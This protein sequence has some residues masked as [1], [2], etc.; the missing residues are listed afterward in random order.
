MASTTTTRG[1]NYYT[2]KQVVTDLK[3]T[4]KRPV[5]VIRCHGSVTH[6]AGTHGGSCHVYLHNYLQVEAAI[7]AS[8]VQ[9]EDCRCRRLWLPSFVV[10]STSRE[11]FVDFHLHACHATVIFD[12]WAK[13]NIPQSQDT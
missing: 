5:T 3:L 7:H 4:A 2:E 1:T 10:L 11:A 9:A 12:T 6:T 8:L 13:E